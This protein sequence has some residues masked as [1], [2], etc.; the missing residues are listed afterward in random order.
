M[1][2]AKPT[3]LSGRINSLESQAE[4]ARGE[5]ERLRKEESYLHEQME[6]AE[7][8]LAYYEALLRDLR[9]QVAPRQQLREV[10]TKI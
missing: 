9:K 8:Q 2:R 5:L 10:M 7:G 3:S 4:E 1:A 6:K